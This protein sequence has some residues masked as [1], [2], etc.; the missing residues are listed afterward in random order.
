M[1]TT[2]MAVF[3]SYRPQQGPACGWVGAELFGTPDARHDTSSADRDR[4]CRP[5]QRWAAGMRSQPGLGCW[6]RVYTG[7]DAGNRL[8]GPA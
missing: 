5:H 4:R 3:L 7:D 1:V 2:A 8:R 6:P